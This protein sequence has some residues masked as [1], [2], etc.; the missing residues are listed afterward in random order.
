MSKITRGGKELPDFHV[1]AKVLIER[2]K[3]LRA[4]LKLLRT[5]ALILAGAGILFSSYLANALT[6]RDVFMPFVEIVRD[7]L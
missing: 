6:N 1:Y 4:L 3:Y 7:I 2:Y 5:I